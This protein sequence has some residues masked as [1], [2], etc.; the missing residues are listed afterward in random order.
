MESKR[1]TS[2]AQP[3]K[4]TNMWQEILR[5]AMPKKQIENTNVFVFG[6]K[7]TGKRSLFNVMNRSIF[8]DGDDSYK[9]LLQIDEESS[10]F[11]LLDYTYINI[12]DNSEDYPEVIGKLSV[13]IM[14]D[15]IDKD[16][17]LAF[18]KPEDIIHGIC[19]IMVDLSR[20]WLL[21]QSLE[22]WIKFVQEVFAQLISKLPDDK[23]EEVKQNVIDKIKLYKEPEIDEQGKY[24]K[25]KMEEEEKKKLLN[26]PLKEGVLNTN[27]GIPIVFVINKSDVVT[28]SSEKKTFEKNSEFILSHV[29]AMA[30][31]YGATIVYTSG[32]ASFNVNLLYDYICHILFNFDLIHKP[33]LADKEAYFI[34]AGYDS[35]TL[36]ES[37]KT[38][39][40][41]L[42]QKYEETIPPIVSKV[43]QEEDI[44]CED[45]NTFFESLKKSGMKGKEQAKMSDYFSENKKTN[46]DAPD[47]RNFE[48]NIPMGRN[49][50][51]LEDKD[52]KYADKKKLLQN[53]LDT[54][55][56]LAKKENK[57][58]PADEEKKRKIREKMLAKIG[59]AKEKKQA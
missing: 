55:S 48:T 14:N 18:L 24:I 51:S 44:Q 45:T 31:E 26:T 1:K 30:L 11:G 34:P 19:L 59:K 58:D 8:T 50:I 41:Y 33:N 39:K 6:D 38:F 12:K 35:S 9:R 53:K 3:A 29:R 37:N 4:T 47:M 17:I 15:F 43:A 25:K 40:D 57:G 27:C 36:L 49:P 16:K 46:I 23:Q 52:K 5:E 2:S 21:K 13:W 54:K 22:K 56:S 28:Q 10:R 20:P 42:D 7:S 32:K